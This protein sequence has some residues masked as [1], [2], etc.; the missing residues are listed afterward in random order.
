MII[1]LLFVSLIYCGLDMT[2]FVRC[3]DDERPLLPVCNMFDGLLQ[4]KVLI[5]MKH[6]DGFSHISSDTDKKSAETRGDL[7]P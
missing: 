2:S 1:N 6:T 5:A 7:V 4:Y 3:F